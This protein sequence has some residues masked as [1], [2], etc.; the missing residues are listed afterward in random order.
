MVG[1]VV[2]AREKLSS[3]LQRKVRHIFEGRRMHWETVS[4]GAPE[5]GSSIK[6][7]ASL[8]P[9]I[10][11]DTEELAR[12]VS[13]TSLALAFD[14]AGKF[15]VS[16]YRKTHPYLLV[17]RKGNVVLLPATRFNRAIHFLQRTW[18]RDFVPGRWRAKY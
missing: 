11:Q 16:R 1:R 9:R 10:R 4:T 5:G 3:E 2:I 6:A 12:K 15:A 18:F 13:P 17:D 7:Y 8:S 14:T